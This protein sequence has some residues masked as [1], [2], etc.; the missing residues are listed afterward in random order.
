MGDSTPNTRNLLCNVVAPGSRDQGNFPLIKVAY[1]F[2]LS[3][4]KMK[5]LAA[6]TPVRSAIGTWCFLVSRSYLRR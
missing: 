1:R 3:R 5:P 2:L 4:V 6:C